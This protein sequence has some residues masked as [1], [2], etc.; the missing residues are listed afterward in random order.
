MTQKISGFVW[1]RSDNLDSVK[2]EIK[3]RSKTLLDSQVNHE[4]IDDNVASPATHTK[5]LFYGGQAIS[6]VLK[7][8]IS[9]VDDDFVT[10][11]STEITSPIDLSGTSSDATFLAVGDFIRNVE[12]LMLLSRRSFLTFP[13]K[14]LLWEFDSSESTSKNIT[15]YVFDDSE[16][17][18]FKRGEEDTTVINDIEVFGDLLLGYHEKNLGTVT[19]PSQGTERGGAFI[20]FPLNLQVVTGTANISDGGANG[21]AIPIENYEYDPHGKTLTITDVTWSNQPSSPNDYVWTK[22]NYEI[23]DEV[24]AINGGTTKNKRHFKIAATTQQIA[25]VGRRSLKAY[26]PQLLHGTDF[27]NI[28]QKIRDKFQNINRRYTIKAPFMINCL[29][30]NLQVKLTSDIMKFYNTSNGDEDL[31]NIT[32]PVRSI[33]WKY[34]ECTTT[35]EVGDYLYDLYDTGKST[36]DTANNLVTG[37]NQTNTAS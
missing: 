7:T 25:D 8:I 33:I 15:G 22:Y 31:D 11:R 37:V 26:I 1:N 36:N 10:F 14:T 23:T 16:Y 32:L 20:Y 34:P 24:S 19:S 17:Q 13:T 18:I 12:V 2:V 28:A 9:Y 5:N 27:Q 35:I 4:I 3:S 21:G 29:R 6:A 30:E